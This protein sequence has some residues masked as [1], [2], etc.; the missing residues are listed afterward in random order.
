MFYYLLRSTCISSTSL[1]HV[2]QIR[3]LPF[4]KEKQIVYQ[5]NFQLCIVGPRGDVELVDPVLACAG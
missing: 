2:N 4:T 3:F 5:L 1:G